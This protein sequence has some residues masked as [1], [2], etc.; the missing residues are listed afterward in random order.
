MQNRSPRR[1]FHVMPVNRHLLTWSRHIHVYLSIALLLAL[2]FFAVTGITLNHA[3]LL[4]GTPLNDSRTLDHLPA[5]PRDAENRIMLSP[6]LGLFLRSEFG[7][8]LD[9]ANARY[10][11]GFLLIDYQRPG[12]TTLVEI[13]QE[14]EE[15][16]VERIDYGLIAVLNDLHKGRHTEV[17]WNWLIDASGVLLVVFA[18]AGFILLLPNRRR[19]RRVLVYSGLGMGGLAVVYVGIGLM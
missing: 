6:E 3:S 16:Y 14:R 1:S 10:E 17:L 12:A 13:D 5:L 18:L 4:T 9:Q 19:L 7:I 2:V 11:D 8:R 15:A